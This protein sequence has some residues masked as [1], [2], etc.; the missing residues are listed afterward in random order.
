MSF[1][2]QR[3][4]TSVRIGTRPSR[5]RLLFNSD[6]DWD[7]EEEP[8]PCAQAPSDPDS[9]DNEGDIAMQHPAAPCGPLTLCCT[10]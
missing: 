10:V 5:S 3:S 9:D 4:S 1:T 2:Y 6:S 7:S 8:I